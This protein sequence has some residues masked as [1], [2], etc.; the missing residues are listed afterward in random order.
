MNTPPSLDIKPGAMRWFNTLLRKAAKDGIVTVKERI[1]PDKAAALLS[2]NPTNRNI[3]P[4]KIVQMTSDLEAGRFVFNGESII[5]SK[6]GLLNDGQHRLFACIKSGI[7]FDTILVVGA[8]RETRYTIDTGSAKSAGDHLGIQGVHNSNTSAAIARMV[9]A[10]R[11]G[12]EKSWVQRNRISSSQQIQMVNSDPLVRRIAGWIDAQRSKF[13]NIINPSLVGFIYYLLAEKAPAEADI[14]MDQL[15]LG[16]G[17][18]AHSP[19][20]LARE[21]LRQHRMND[22]Q[23]IET[24]I[25]AWNHWCVSPTTTISR[26]HIMDK[27]PDIQFPSVNYAENDLYMVTQKAPEPKTRKAKVKAKA[28]EETETQEEVLGTA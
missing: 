14:F 9:L 25:R 1:T 26:L 21:K 3:R 6:D 27:I 18:D 28:V 19:I 8:D 17:L 4:V 11:L 15:R 13:R 2:R 24:V 20:F 22:Y 5:V 12:G 10:W 23:R 7:A 16:A